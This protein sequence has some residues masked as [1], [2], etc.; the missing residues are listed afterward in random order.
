MKTTEIRFY[1]PSDNS[2]AKP[3]T[4]SEPKSVA[5]TGY[6]SPSGKVVFPAKSVAQ[7]PFDPENTSFKIGTQQ[8]KRKVKALYLV[9]TGGEEAGTFKMV[10]AAKSYTIPL[11]LILQKGGV[12]YEDAKYTFTVKPFDYEPGTTGYALQLNSD[13]PK[14][15]YTGKPRGRKK[16][17]E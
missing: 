7:L 10:K 5:I 6:I 9:P 3:K 15:P 8:G 1:S 16:T 13:A 17:T 12:K 2:T 14:V 11:A 4:K